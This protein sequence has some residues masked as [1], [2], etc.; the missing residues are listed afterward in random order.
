MT[1]L[2]T[3]GH[4]GTTLAP[5]LS[6]RTGVKALDFY[7]RAF[8]ATELFKIEDD[9]GEIVA[10]LSIEG[11]VFWIADESPGHLNFSP[12]SLGGATTRMV[13]TV[14]NP[15]TVFEQ[16]IAAGATSVWPVADQP[17]GWRLGRL[18]DPFGHHWEIGKPLCSAST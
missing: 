7:R 14:T 17:Y 10:R 18:I 12:S 3:S 15:D 11:A 9:N 13:L 6:V 16:A 4:Q 5:L 1:S 8:G 2:P